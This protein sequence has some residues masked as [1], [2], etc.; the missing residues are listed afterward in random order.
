MD[1]NDV[2]GTK[3]ART[4]FARRGIDISMADVRVMHG[5]CFVRGKLRPMPKW[6]IRHVEAECQKIAGIIKK[7][8]EIK[9]CIMECTYQEPYF[10]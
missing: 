8:A 9:E 2:R 3:Y 7:Q 5:V 6:D 4:A 10:K 1:I